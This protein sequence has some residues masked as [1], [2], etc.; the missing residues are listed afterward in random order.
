MISFLEM[1]P[2][3]LQLELT[4]KQK[5]IHSKIINSKPGYGIKQVPKGSDLGE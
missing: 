5:S 2:G 3:K 1:I 4:S